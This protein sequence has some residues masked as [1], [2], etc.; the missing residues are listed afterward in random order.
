VTYIDPVHGLEN[1]KMLLSSIFEVPI[2]QAQV[3]AAFSRDVEQ[4]T[5]LLYGSPGCGK[6]LLT[7]WIAHKTGNWNEML[8]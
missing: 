5:I 4:K 8:A 6:T 3:L 1:S 2:E 7:K